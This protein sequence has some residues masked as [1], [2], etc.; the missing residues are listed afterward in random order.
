MRDKL[1]AKQLKFTREYAKDGNGT[2]AAIRAGYA[3]NSADVEASRLL[4]NAKIGKAVAKFQENHRLKTEVTIESLAAELE[5]DRDRARQLDQTA[6]AVT[7]TVQIA[8]LY[9]LDINRNIN[10]N[11]GLTKIEIIR[12]SDD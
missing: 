8:K 9:G 3:P 5:H 10:E 11:N 12:Y 1:T 4:V 2:Q 6:T 7:A